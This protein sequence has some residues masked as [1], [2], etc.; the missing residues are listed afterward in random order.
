MNSVT[1]LTT[2]RRRRY[3]APAQL[4]DQAAAE[5]LKELTKATLA[6]TKRILGGGDVVRENAE[7]QKYLK[8]ASRNIG[9]VVRMLTPPPERSSKGVKDLAANVG[10]AAQSGTDSAVE[11]H[12]ASLVKRGILTDSTQLC[13]NLGWTRQSLSKA[14][15]AHRIFF[16]EQAGVRLYPAFFAD[17]KFER[18]HLEA[19]S[20]AMGALP[21]GSKLQF[22]LSHRGSLGGKSVL[23]ALARGQKDKVIAAAEGF[24]EG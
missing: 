11:D 22:F 1:T 24:A 2:D 15:K 5:E 16:I 18:G 6:L 12:V 4:S 10:A 13:A 21:G 20:K 7:T 23:D 14:L 17:Q 19:V 9:E 3:D 8:A